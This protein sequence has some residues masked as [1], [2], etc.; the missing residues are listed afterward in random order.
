MPK[1][2]VVTISHSLGREQARARLRERIGAFRQ[3]LGTYRVAL[4]R[5]DWEGDRLTV[6][7]SALGQTLQGTVDVMDDH[8]RIE[9]QLP[10]MLAAFAER[11]RGVVQQK[12][13]AL[14]GPGEKRD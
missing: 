14:L 8:L 1:S 7:L 10:L 2:V 5:D 11:I 3:M 4:V 13:P 9:V 12:A 6:G